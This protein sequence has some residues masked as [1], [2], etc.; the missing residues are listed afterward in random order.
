LALRYFYRQAGPCLQ[1]AS[2]TQKLS[3]TRS[4]GSVKRKARAAARRAAK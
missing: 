4:P 2:P 3:A 1:I